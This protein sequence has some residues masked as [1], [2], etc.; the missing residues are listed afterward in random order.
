MSRALLALALIA[1]PMAA[2]AQGPPPPPRE[3]RTAR[4]NSSIVVD[5]LLTEPAWTVAEACSN[6]T[7]RDPVEGARPSQRT[8][9]RVLF[10][11]DALFVGARLYDSAPDSIVAE[12]ARRDAG[13][14]SDRFFVYLDPFRDRRSGYYFAVNAAGTQYDGTLYNDAWSD[15][16]WDGVWDGRAR[17]DGQGWT[18]EM[19]IP[20][21]QMRFARAN[22]QTWGV[23]FQ[24]EMGRGFE[25]IYF[26]CRPKTSSGFVSVFPTLVGLQDVNPTNAIEVVPYATSK[27]EFLRH[28][29]FDPFNDGSRTRPNLGGDLRMPI[30]SKLTLNAT[31]NPDFGQVEVD[32]AVVNLSDVETFFPEKRPFFVEGSSI[33]ESGQQGASDYWGFNFPQPT[34]FYSRRI[35]RAPEGSLPDDAQYSDVPRGTT[36]LGAAKMS[37]KLSS[38]LNVGTLH[39]LTSKE[40]ADH[41]RA[42]LSRF[43]SEV[44]PLSYYGVARMLKEFPERRHGLGM[45]TTLTVRDPDDPALKDQ[46]NR[47][48]L[49]AVVDGWHFVDANK[50]WVLSGWAGAS[51]VT[52]TAAR[53]T[54]LQ[55]SSRRYYQ[56]PDAKSFS[57][58]PD[59]TSLTGAGARVWLNKEK[60]RWMSNSALGFLSPGFEVNDLGFQSRADVIN[61]H[62]TLGYRW[63][64]PT[65]HVKNHNVFGAL[66]GSADFDGNV[67][68]AG[69][70]TRAFWWYANDWTLNTAFAYNPETVNPRRSRGG[71][72]MLNRPGYEIN[73]FADTDGSRKR[74]YYVSYYQ[75]L[76]PQEN[77]FNYSVNP[78]FVYKPASNVKLEI[79]PGYESGRD[80][81]FY[82][83]TLD[84]PAAIATYGRRYVFARLD[85]QTLSANIRLNVSFTPRMSL[86]FYGQPLIATGRYSDFREL[87]R[88]RSLEFVGQGAGAWTYDAAGRV[89]DPDGAG[90]ESGQV[91]DFNTRSL[92]GNAVFRWE[93]LPGSTLFLVWTQQRTDDESIPDFNLGPSFR[94]LASADA[95]NI[96]LAKLTYYLNL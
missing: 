65:K 81:A 69:A 73:L 1:L 74:Y 59:A 46:F 67:T 25:N 20:F 24:R 52:G 13:T 10:D 49:T 88:P 7:Q 75:Y 66:F 95:D 55:Q 38:S 15:D 51:H 41:Q 71:P 57:L 31:I 56:R 53:I 72:L 47:S 4:V 40:T 37:G 68:W 42:D 6:F 63:T 58:D 78:Y 90:P 32:P 33:F 2:S 87:A 30:G 28:D 96:F 45:L 34:F 92:R 44:E 70:W 5:G 9:V 77:S 48:A 12:L 86:Q 76:Q 79:G 50:A 62:A 93:Y 43:E 29:A 60:G 84:D 91:K 85:Q 17:R 8:V 3:L 14:R 35:G 23:N 21:S 82:V 61:S 26:V 19:R 11:R 18:V 16:S 54:A 94:R 27:A 80:G 36:I 83:A 22:P 64:E 89:F 39:A